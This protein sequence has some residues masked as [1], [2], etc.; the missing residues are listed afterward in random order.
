MPS[1][2]IFNPEGG[3]RIIHRLRRPVV[4]K[5]DFCDSP[6]QFL[7]DWHDGTLHAK[8][9]DKKLC[10]AHATRVNFQRDYCPEHVPKP[11]KPTP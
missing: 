3:W 1:D 6:H 11:E 2:V 8:T 10:P 7:C 4:A 9:C 5:C